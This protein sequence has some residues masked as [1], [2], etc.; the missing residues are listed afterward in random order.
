[1]AVPRGWVENAFRW[2][3][4]KLANDQHLMPKERILTERA[5]T[6]KLLKKYQREIVEGKRP[7]LR[8]IAEGDVPYNRH[9]IVCVS[10]IL[11]RGDETVIEVTDGWYALPAACDAALSQKIAEGKICVGRKL[12]VCAAQLQG[13]HAGMDP[14]ECWVNQ[15]AS[16]SCA[17][18]IDKAML[19]NCPLLIFHLNST[20]MAAWHAKLG[21]VP[22]FPMLCKRLA[23]V[24]P[25]GGVIPFLELVVL[26]VMPM[27]YMEKGADRWTCRSSQEQAA[28]EEDARRA[29]N[30]ESHPAAE[31][32]GCPGVF[33]RLRGALA[34]DLAPF[35]RIGCLRRSGAARAQ[36]E[37]GRR[38][39]PP[40]AIL[41]AGAHIAEKF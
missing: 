29:G 37:S 6:Q 3:V 17:E 16:R 28:A 1:M 19:L 36:L 9:M 21:F 4:W 40:A 39:C 27:R 41:R 32:V 25:D 2:C 22:R 18:R 15:P 30:G 26:R 23:A 10:A 7:A 35:E 24:R 5:V 33:Y 38:E 11:V 8:S 14:L 34:H 12:A 20:R 31:R 13:V